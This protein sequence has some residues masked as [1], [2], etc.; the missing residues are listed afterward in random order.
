MKSG[1]AGSCVQ[2]LGKLQ[3]QSSCRTADIPGNGRLNC[4]SLWRGVAGRGW[5]GQR[6]PVRAG[7]APPQGEAEPGAS[8]TNC[9]RRVRKAGAWRN[10]AAPDVPWQLSRTSCRSWAGTVLQLPAGNT[11]NYSSRGARALP[12]KQDQLSRVGSSLWRDGAGSTGEGCV[13]DKW[14]LFL[15]VTSWSF[16][17]VLCFPHLFLSI[18]LLRRL[19]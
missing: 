14:V 1:Q 10:G 19:H 5:R 9:L 11:T 4:A 16:S 3:E 8:C 17:P 2:P 15:E 12:G 6:V 7:G 18:C 13:G